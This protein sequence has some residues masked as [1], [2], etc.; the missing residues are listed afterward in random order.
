[1]TPTIKA[2]ILRLTAIRFFPYWDTTVDTKGLWARMERGTYVAYVSL[3]ADTEDDKFEEEAWTAFKR[4][5][6]QYE[7]D[8]TGDSDG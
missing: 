7:L 8:M 3:P 1:M 6:D 5:R 2:D 4:V